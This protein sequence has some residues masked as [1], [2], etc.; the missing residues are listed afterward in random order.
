MHTT[1]HRKLNTPNPCIYRTSLSRK[2]RLWICFRRIL[3]GSPRLYSPCSFLTRLARA[4]KRLVYASKS[5][6][7]AGNNNAGVLKVISMTKC[8][9]N[10]LIS[11]LK[12]D[13]QF[14]LPYYN[15]NGTFSLIEKFLPILNTPILPV[16]IFSG[17]YFKR[18]R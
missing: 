1:Q 8:L 14:N 15:S 6:L 7:M 18:L 9:N 17:A 11:Y 4:R 2:R 16:A 3:F 12:I 13:L 5:R 10:K